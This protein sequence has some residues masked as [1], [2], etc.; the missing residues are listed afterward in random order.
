MINLNKQLVTK[1]KLLRYITDIE[2]YQK[3]INEEIIPGKV[4]LSPLRNENTASFGFF[5]GEN[6]EICF[7]DFKLGG[8]DC[9]KFVQMKFNL[10][11]FEALSKIAIDFGME[12]DFIVKKI[13]KSKTNDI[14]PIN[15]DEFLHKA[16]TLN[17]KKTKRE[18]KS[19]DLLY[20]QQYGISLKTLEIFN[21]E[22]ISYFFI[23]DKI[24]TAD[25]HAYCFKEFKDDLETYKIYQPFN[26]IYKWINSHNNSIWQGWSQLPEKGDTLII[27]KSLKDVMAI[28]EITGIPSIALQ[29]ENLLP[30]KQVFQELINRFEDIYIFYDNDFDKENNWGQIFAQKFKESFD[31]YNIIIKDEYE[32]K[33][34]S[35]FVKKYG[36]IE[37]K[38]LITSQLLLF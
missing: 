10:N 18:W 22:P 14:I 19:Y 27:T 13:E 29:C 23:N 7:K 16:G 24:I 4:M 34:F 35:D 11:Y 36:L 21:V 6:N 1:N 33:D 8:G 38:Q 25:K 3:Y 31:V 5:K 12:D 32:C 15:R 2:I 37:A 30:K 28:H 26:K 9:I 17:I 20:W